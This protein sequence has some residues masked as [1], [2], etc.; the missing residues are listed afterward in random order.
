MK[1]NLMIILLA[2]MLPSLA[3]SQCRRFTKV[4]CLPAL[5]E[6]IPNDNFNSA[7]L[8][9]GDEAELTMTF[10][11]GQ[12]YRVMVCAEEILG[13]LSYKI[14]NDDGESVFDSESTDTDHLDFS[15]ANTQQLHMILKVPPREN[16]NQLIHEGCATVLVGYKDE[17]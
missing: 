10:Y 14:V 9:P 5:G 7:V 16:P 6:Y 17:S 2:V 4:K 12:D 13:D 11:A 1:K 15:V 3:F 8:I